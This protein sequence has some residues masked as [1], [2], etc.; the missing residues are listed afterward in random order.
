MTQKIQTLPELKKTLLDK[1]LNGISWSGIA[2]ELYPEEDPCVWRSI[3]WRIAKD[4][5]EPKNNKLR[6]RL[7]LPFIKTVTACSDCNEIHLSGC[8][9]ADVPTR[10][11]TAIVPVCDRCGKI[12]TTKRCTSSK[13]KKR[14]RLSINLDNPGSAAKSIKRYMDGDLIKELVKLLKG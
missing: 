5:Y 4:D 2:K 12:H 10:G 13:H 14:N 7:G 9:N 1:K 11:K 6:K 8:P 3:L